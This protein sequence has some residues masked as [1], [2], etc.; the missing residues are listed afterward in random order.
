MG[1]LRNLEYGLVKL[2]LTSLEER[3]LRG[4]LI[5]QFKIVKNIDQVEWHH[6]LNK[7]S[8]HYCTRSHNYGFAK[9]IVGNCTPRTN[10]FTNRI[11]NV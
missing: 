7:L 3:R 6:P 11:A 8:N 9:Q 4:D 2:N 10:F 5:E 1:E